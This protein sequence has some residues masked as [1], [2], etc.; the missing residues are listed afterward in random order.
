MF[1]DLNAARNHVGRICADNNF[2]YNYHPGIEE[3][4]FRCYVHF[5]A[6]KYAWQ[7]GKFR[8]DGEGEKRRLAGFGDVKKQG[9]GVSTK[10]YGMGNG[11]ARAR[12]ED[13]KK[14]EAVFSKANDVTS[15]FSATSTLVTAND[16]FEMPVDQNG[17][18]TGILE[19]G[20]DT[21]VANG[22]E[23]WAG[24]EDVS[25]DSAAGIEDVAKVEEKCDPFKVSF[26]LRK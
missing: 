3:Q 19:F 17:Q 24:E 12:E 23:V 1:L 10:A 14:E 6:A 22:C 7:A 26:H 4:K 9:F 13:L 11:R 16:S 25:C 8:L 2:K 5:N 15:T 21:T 18:G 20:N